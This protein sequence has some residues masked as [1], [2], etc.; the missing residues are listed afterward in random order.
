MRNPFKREQCLFSVD[1]P[2]AIKANKYGWLN[3]IHYMAPHTLAGVGNLCPHASAGCR[4]LCLGEYSGQAGMAQG[5]KL[6]SVRLSRR[7]KARRF[8]TD[9]LNYVALMVKQ[10]EGLESKAQRKG[11]ALAIRPNG[12]TD[13]AWEGVG[14]I[15]NGQRYRN[16]MDAFPQLVFVDYTK[17]PRRFDRPLPA[18]YFLTFSRSETNEAECA[19]LLARGV[20]VAVVF[21]TD[22]PA[23][24]H[25]YSVID[26]DA[27]DL[28][29]LDPRGVVVGLTPKGHKAKRDRSGFV[30]R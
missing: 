29:H 21:A 15:R 30:V 16:L 3:A 8:M 26:G 12:S 28:R 7:V 23:T 14:V 5:R 17:N 2:K 18:N 20:N 24:W 6:N 11:L 25:G 1:S 4:A 27:H 9:R 22:K 13:I 10:I 19:A